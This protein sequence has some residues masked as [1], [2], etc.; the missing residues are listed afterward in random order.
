MVQIPE[1]NIADEKVPLEQAMAYVVDKY[2]YTPK[3][4]RNYVMRKRHGYE[5]RETLPDGTVRVTMY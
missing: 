4:A 5:K 2:G 1:L 3:E